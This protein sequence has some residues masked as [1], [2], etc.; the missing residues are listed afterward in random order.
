MYMYYLVAFMYF[1]V[2]CTISIYSFTA[3][4]LSVKNSRVINALVNH[5]MVTSMSTSKL[6][7]L[8]IAR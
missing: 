5:T 3:G 7:H 2:V 1:M 4:S 6:I 8:L